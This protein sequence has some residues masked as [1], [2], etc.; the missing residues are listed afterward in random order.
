MASQF[1]PGQLVRISGLKT[2]LLNGV[3]GRLGAFDAEAGRWEVLH[4]QTPEA[5]KAFPGGARVKVANLTNA[6]PT[7]RPKKSKAA[8]PAAP[9]AP[10]AAP[11]A[12][13][14]LWTGKTGE[15]AYKWFVYAF[16]LRVEDAYTSCG[17]TY[18]D[19]AEALGS[20]LSDYWEYSLGVHT[21]LKRDFMRWR[22]SAFRNK[23]FPQWWLDDGEDGDHD[24]NC[25]TLANT[26]I[27]MAVEQHDIV[28]M[29][30]VAG[31][32]RLR[33]LG[34]RVTGCDVRQKF[35]RKNEI[36]LVGF[37]TE[38]DAAEFRGEE[39]S[40]SDEEAWEE[41]EEEEE[42]WEEE[43]CTDEGEEGEEEE[44]DEEAEESESVAQALE[45]LNLHVPVKSPLLPRAPA[46]LLAAVRVDVNNGFFKPMLSLESL[47][48]CGLSEDRIRCAYMKRQRARGSRTRPLPS[49]SARL[50]CIDCLAAEA[51]AE[52]VPALA[53]AVESFIDERVENAGAACME[54]QGLPM[55]SMGIRDPVTGQ[56]HTQS[57]Y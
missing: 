1:S 9:R 56:F 13:D 34:T 53:A 41:E 10:A 35:N 49:A 47:R 8:A 44:E 43:E 21:C 5:R 48:G 54:L 12:G 42:G 14:D 39:I 16:M 57:F 30:G 23:A 25:C 32:A 29:Y 7:G 33:A 40:D 31:L 17:A 26:L 4:L 36:P 15:E 2:P 6:E 18:G 51:H 27:G 46:P 45:L 22:A 24:V 19:Y 11:P 37:Y 50:F 3:Q 52:G 28:E 38:K 55:A 20:G